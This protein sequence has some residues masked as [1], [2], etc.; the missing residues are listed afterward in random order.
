MGLA[1]RDLIGADLLIHGLGRERQRQSE[2]R[3]NR[4][5]VK[6]FRDR[7]R[8]HT[9][10]VLVVENELQEWS[11]IPATEAGADNVGCDGIG[12]DGCDDCT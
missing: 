10:T 3:A 8:P 6:V 5:G 1:L 9:S 11:D 2:Q 7:P 12:C 4:L